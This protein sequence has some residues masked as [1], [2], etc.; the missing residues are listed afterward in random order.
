MTEQDV[1]NAIKTI[2]TYC[3]ERSDCVSCPLLPNCEKTGAPIYW[4]LL[5][6]NKE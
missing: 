3:R 2:Q 1:N 6:E 5:P 4:N